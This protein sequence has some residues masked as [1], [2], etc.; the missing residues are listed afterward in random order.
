MPKHDP[1]EIR[2]RLFGCVGSSDASR[3]SFVL[4]S[5][6]DKALPVSLLKAGRLPPVDAEISVTG[7]LRLGEGE[8]VV[9]EM[10]SNDQWTVLS[11]SKADALIQ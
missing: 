9:L 8:G 1:Y 5:P 10:T 3:R 2:V 11:R 4:K 7:R 6:D